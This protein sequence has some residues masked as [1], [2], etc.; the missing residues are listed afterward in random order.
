M[1]RPRVAISGSRTF[2]D[3]TLVERIVD[4]LIERGAKILVPCSDSGC[5]AGVDTFVHERVAQRDADHDLFIA[6]WKRYGKRA[7]FMRN[8]TMIKKATELIAIMATGPSP[9]TSHALLCA[10]RLGIT[11]HVFYDGKWTSLTA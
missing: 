6:Q 1:S 10:Q 8:E 5:A 4:R 7:G 2:T 9:G 11:M 3:R